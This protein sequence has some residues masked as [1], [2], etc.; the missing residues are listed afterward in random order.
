MIKL[1]KLLFEAGAKAGKVELV[2]TTPEK[3]R[4]YAEKQFEKYN[5]TLDKELPDFDKNYKAAQSK[6]KLGHTKRKDMPVIENKD[7]K[8]LQN[9]LSKGYIDITEPHSKEVSGTNPFPEGLTGEDAKQWLKN[10]LKKYDKAKS[11]KDDIVSVT[12]SSVPVNKLKPI[13]QQ[14]YFDKSIDVMARLGVSSSKNFMKTQIFIISKD[15]FIIDGHHR[16]QSMM[17]IDPSMKA[18][19]LTIDL[20]ISKLLPMTKS[21][22]DAVGN[23]RNA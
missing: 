11:D 12:K 9:R 8:D 21:Y 3:A 13:Q 2:N 19:T 20:P 10:G 17:L 7:I 6:A 18:N 1:T 16:F 5:T 14:I 15:N 23:K 22:G 4:E